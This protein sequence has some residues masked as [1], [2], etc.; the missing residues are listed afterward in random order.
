LSVVEGAS[1]LLVVLPGAEDGGDTWEVPDCAGEAALLPVGF[2]LKNPARVFCP[3]AVPEGVAEGLERLMGEFER[4][5]D[6]LRDS[7]GGPLF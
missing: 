4:G 7:D 6:R 2:G 5:W 1:M 3:L